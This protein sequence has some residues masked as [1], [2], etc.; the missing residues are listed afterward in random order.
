MMLV[1]PARLAAQR[2]L[3]R[4]VYEGRPRESHEARTWVSLQTSVTSGMEGMTRSS[5]DRS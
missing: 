5:I 3:T 1:N 2:S 4:I